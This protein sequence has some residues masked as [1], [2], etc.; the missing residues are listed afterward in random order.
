MRPPFGPLRVNRN[1]G[2]C[3]AAA[4]VAPAGSADV[5]S[6]PPRA[7]LTSPSP[8]MKKLSDPWPRVACSWSMTS[9][10]GGPSSDASGSSTSAAV[11][12]PWASTCGL[13][14]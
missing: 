7:V 14:A 4:A 8:R 2:A 1:G 6:R 13:L 3:A 12:W 10:S 5:S 9:A 11:T